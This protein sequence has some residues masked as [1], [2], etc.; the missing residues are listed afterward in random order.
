MQATGLGPACPPLFEFDQRVGA[1]VGTTALLGVSGAGNMDADTR[2][3]DSH[4]LL[5]SAADFPS[6]SSLHMTLAVSE[7]GID[8]KPVFRH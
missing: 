1:I 2:D 6:P 5:F 4:H 7:S 3:T 8:G